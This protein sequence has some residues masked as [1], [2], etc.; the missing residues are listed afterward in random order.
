[1][2][3]SGKMTFPRK[4]LAVVAALGAGLALAG[5]PP[6]AEA[7]SAEGLR[8]AFADYTNNILRVSGGEAPVNLPFRL[9]AGPAAE[10][11]RAA[12]AAVETVTTSMPEHVRQ[13]LS[14]LGVLAPT[15]QWLLRRCKPGV[16][17]ETDYLNP[18]SHPLVWRARDFDLGALAK[19][20]GMMASNSIPMIARIGSLYEDYKVSPIRRA[21]PL[22]DYPDPRTELLCETPYG[23]A[24]VLRAP[25]NA[26]KFRFWAS[27]W[28]LQDRNV[29]YQWVQLTPGKAT[30]S[31]IQGQ[32]L[33]SPQNGYAEIVVNWSGIRGHV[34]FAVFARYGEGPYGPPSM[35]SFLVVPNEARKYDRQGR[36]QTIA[37]RKADAVLPGLYQNKPW[38]DAYEVDDQGRILGFLRTRSGST[39]EERFSAMGE[40]IVETHP[41]GSPKTARRV[42]YFTPPEDP[43]TLDYEIT[44]ETI[45]YR[46]GT[47]E[48]RS[49]GEFPV[50]RGRSRKS[51]L[52]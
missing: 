4:P 12:E 47:F 30:L 7:W 40:F 22:V 20:A 48:P 28:P 31:R 5:T 13:Y 34:D 38:T 46:P 41:D 14:G 24:I 25:E 8:L 27:S 15:V 29:N 36:I 50:V 49:R 11:L 21:E 45:R 37:Y 32:Q 39:L 35:I 23:R 19:A 16:T 43:S 1:M 52:K 18:S 51:R 42:R 2:E 9:A 3:A 44:G 17:N 26:R 33:L 10:D 6:T